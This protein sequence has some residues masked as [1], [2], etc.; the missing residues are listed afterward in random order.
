MYAQPPKNYP[1]ERTSERSSIWGSFG[2]RTC[3]VRRTCTFAGGRTCRCGCLCL[4]RRTCTF[5]V[6]FKRSKLLP[7]LRSIVVILQIKLLTLVICGVSESRT[8]CSEEECVLMK[9]L[10]TQIYVNVRQEFGPWC[11][12]ILLCSCSYVHVHSPSV[13]ILYNSR[14]KRSL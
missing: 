5:V 12:K 10:T 11:A 9:S 1:S 13:L 3:L 4:V 14:S 8:C 6:I 2:G 7:P